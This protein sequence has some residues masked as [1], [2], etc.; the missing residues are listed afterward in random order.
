MIYRI[1]VTTR[2]GEVEINANHWQEGESEG[3]ALTDFVTQWADEE[4][5]VVWDD[6]MWNG[7]PVA[8]VA[9][10]ALGVD[11][12]VK[13]DLSRLDFWD[14]DWLVSITHITEDPDWVAPCPQCTSTDGPRLCRTHRETATLIAG[15]HDLL[16]Y[17]KDKHLPPLSDPA[18]TLRY[19]K[20][21]FQ[22]II[23]RIEK[24]G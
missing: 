7:N 16:A 6:P 9:A 22:T 19:F 10:A 11:G 24:G 20:S 8:D 15:V 5:D 18:Q 2:Y 4:V 3:Q 14:G 23:D 12:V 17:G 1:A 13:V 21:R